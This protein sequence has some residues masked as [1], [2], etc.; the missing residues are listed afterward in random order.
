MF[1]LGRI[2]M[3]TPRSR[4]SWTKFS[5]LTV[6]PSRSK[7]V[8]HQHVAGPDLSERVL[9]PWVGKGSLQIANSQESSP[10]QTAIHE[11]SGH[12]LD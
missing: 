10:T 8:D 9:R 2:R 3:P 4:S 11:K 7:G 12:R 6:W 1:E 5:I